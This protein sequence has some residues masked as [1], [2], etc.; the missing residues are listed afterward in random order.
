MVEEQ[1][2]KKFTL[3]EL[4]VVIAI[5]G[6]LATLLMPSLGKARDKAKQ[7]VCLNNMKQIS[8]AVEMYKSSSDNRLPKCVAAVGTNWTGVGNNQAW[9]SYIN[10]YL[11]QPTDVNGD[12]TL[13]T[14]NCPSSN[15]E[16]ATGGGL[17]WNINYL[18]YAPID[19][20]ITTIQKY[21][22]YKFASITEPTE[23]LLV[24]DTTDDD[25]WEARVCRKPSG[26]INRIG[27]RH[28]GKTNVLWA[29]SHVTA[30]S[31]SKMVIGA[32][33]KQ[34]YYY[35]ADKENQN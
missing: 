21:E 28:S 3:I 32:E 29:D 24:G 2:V 5:I 22:G 26:N 34:N 11:E 10:V 8:V 25:A 18:A 14:F 6:I 13:G 9:K 17:G 20:S 19:P 12:L 31:P 33:G 15:T 16:F 1:Y 30:E 4:L 35:L 23:T 27:S 7:V